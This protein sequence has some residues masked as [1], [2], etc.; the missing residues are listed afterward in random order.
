MEELE[1]YLKEF[2]GKNQHKYD[3]P[4]YDIL[5]ELVNSGVINEYDEDRY[6]TE[7]WISSGKYET[8]DCNILLVTNS[9]SY[10]LTLFQSRSGSYYS[11]YY[12]SYPEFIS[13]VTLEEYVKPPI[14]FSF[15]YKGQSISID[16]T[17]VVFLGNNVY[18]SV[19]EAIDEI[20]ACAG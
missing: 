15:T 7:D 16:K 11:D 12:Y 5:Y 10:I 13:L 3:V 18:S 8:R 6:D 9:G 2:F 1:V 20:I 17:N 19:E 14:I 4:L